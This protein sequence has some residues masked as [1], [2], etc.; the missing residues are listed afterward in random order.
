M[1]F[2]VGMLVDN[3][4]RSIEPWGFD[5]R[6]HDI[7]QQNVSHGGIGTD[8]IRKAVSCDRPAWTYLVAGQD[9]ETDLC[10][11]DEENNVSKTFIPRNIYDFT[12]SNSAAIL[13]RVLS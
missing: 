13:T 4:A 5:V 1:A 8:S 7:T 10:E 12:W 9:T 2:R 11:F 6:G 3:M